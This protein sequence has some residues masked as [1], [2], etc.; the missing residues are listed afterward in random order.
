MGKQASITLWLFPPTEGDNPCGDYLASTR[1]RVKRLTCGCPALSASRF[2]V[3]MCPSAFEA[4]F[5]E[6]FH[7]KPCD[8]PMKVK[9]VKA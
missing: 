1:P 7:M 2:T 8:P 5:P 9:L 3:T 6:D 4:T